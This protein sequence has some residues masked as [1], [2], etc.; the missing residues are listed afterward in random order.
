MQ[1]RK[2]KADLTINV[3][4]Y[5]F[6]KALDHHSLFFKWHILQLPPLSIFCPLIFLVDKGVFPKW[7]GIHWIQQIQGVCGGLS[8]GPPGELLVDCV[9]Y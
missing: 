3:M 2:C 6:S 1:F 9:G 7:T 4:N 5:I 8:D